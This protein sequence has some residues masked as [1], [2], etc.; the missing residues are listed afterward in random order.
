MTKMGSLGVRGRMGLWR[1]DDE[2]VEGCGVLMSWVGKAGVSVESKA[3][4]IRRASIVG[5]TVDG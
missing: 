5:C 3:N 4:I 2:V 1:G